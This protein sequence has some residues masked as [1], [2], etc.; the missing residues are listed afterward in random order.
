MMPIQKINHFLIQL[1][2]IYQ[3][4]LLGVED[5]DT[6]KFMFEAF[7]YHMSSCTHISVLVP[8]GVKF[9]TNKEIQ[10]LIEGNLTC[11]N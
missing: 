9:S 11:D 2:Y 8:L 6:I 1:P 3:E 10:L 7:I 5:Y 4:T